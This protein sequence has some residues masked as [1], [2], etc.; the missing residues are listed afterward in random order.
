MDG[1]NSGSE[2][3]HG[4]QNSSSPPV[5]TH[6]LDHS[7]LDDLTG[8]VSMATAHFFMQPGWSLFL[9]LCFSAGSIFAFSLCFRT[10]KNTEECVYHLL[11]QADLLVVAAVVPFF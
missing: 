9:E 10:S 11:H 8:N 6:Q 4:V 3:T 7:I 2:V 5:E 1:S